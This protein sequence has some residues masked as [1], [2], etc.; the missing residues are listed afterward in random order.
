MLEFVVPGAASRSTHVFESSRSLS[1]GT[2]T[3]VDVEQAQLREQQAAAT[4]LAGHIELQEATRRRQRLA[5]RLATVKLFRTGRRR[6]DESVTRLGGFCIAV[7]LGGAVFVVLGRLVSGT[8]IG[9]LLAALVGIVLA[10]I[11]YLPFSFVPAD[12][13]LEKMIGPLG[14]RFDEADARYLTCAAVELKLNTESA[15]AQA[16]YGRL[17]EVIESRLHWLRTCDWP[18]MTGQTFEAFLAEVFQERGYGVEITAKTGDQGVDLIISRQ[19]TRVAVQAK[20]YVGHPV[21]N[22][23]VQ[24]VHAGKAFHGCQVAALVTN[25][26]YT[27]SARELAERIHCVLIDGSQIPDLIEG[28]IM[29]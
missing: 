21:G 12:E 13:Q 9:I 16:E 4:H 11:G 10:A 7:T 5:S 17:K 2:V 8:A 1:A 23:A 28:R 26:R 22:G 27:D 19:G 3:V 24:E 25:S 6:L 15:A 20:G 29:L 18:K 14:E